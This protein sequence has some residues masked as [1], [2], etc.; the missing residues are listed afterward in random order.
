MSE[1]R[2]PW[3]TS[4]IVPAAVIVIGVVAV[5]FVLLRPSGDDS[6]SS[7][8]KT[9]SAESIRSEWEDRDPDDPMALGAVDA[10]VGLVMFTDFQCPYC[11]Q[12][13]TDTL[14]ELL[15]YTTSGKLRIEFRD[16]N[17]YGDASE[18]AARAAYAAALQGRLLDY[19]RALFA[20]GTPRPKTELHDEALIALAE[21]L[22][23]DVERFRTDYESRRVLSAVRNK[24]SD[25]FTAGTYTTP[26]F[27]LGNE[28]IL[29]AQPTKVFTDALH[30]ALTATGN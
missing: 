6:P 17:V 28:P 16:M 13:S 9:Q 19:H 21:R 30:R 20:G 23:L 25:G 22:D 14:P 8:A 12:W 29:G 26:A 15:P 3:W 5:A 2:R 11:A 4:R 7:T 27:V 1:Q 18:R 24:A 10:P